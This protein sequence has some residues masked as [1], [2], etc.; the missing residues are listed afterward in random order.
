MRSSLLPFLSPHPIFPFPLFRCKFLYNI[1]HAKLRFKSIYDI[2]ENTNALFYF[3]IFVSPFSSPFWRLFFPLVVLLSFRLSSWFT[4]IPVRSRKHASTHTKWKRTLSP[5]VRWHVHN[6][7]RHRMIPA[8]L[9][10]R[11]TAFTNAAKLPAV[12]SLYDARGSTIRRLSID[13]SFVSS[14]SPTL[15]P[16]SSEAKLNFMTTACQID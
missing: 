12:V 9:L 1:K 11:K 5:F 14:R 16:T 15:S 4:L 2:L 6:R 10:R 13:H 7:S 3:S 8:A